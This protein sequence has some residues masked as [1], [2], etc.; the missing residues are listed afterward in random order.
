VIRE[1]I[2]VLGTLPRAVDLFTRQLDQVPHVDLDALAAVQTAYLR[3]LGANG[4]R[5]I[6]ADLVSDL[7]S[8]A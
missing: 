5:T 8:G 4:T 1:A 7:A 2:D 6:V 3:S